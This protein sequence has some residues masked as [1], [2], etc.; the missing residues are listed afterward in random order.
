MNWMEWIGIAATCVVLLSFLQKSELNIRRVNIVGSILFVVYGLFI[1]SL[2]VWLLNGI[3]IIVHIYKLYRLFKSENTAS[4]KSK[5][6]ATRTSDNSNSSYY[7]GYKAGYE[8]GYDDG[9]NALTKTSQYTTYVSER[10][11]VEPRDASKSDDA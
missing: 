2:S 9:F 8:H 4:T 3:C 1:N 10:T 11:K 5:S 7:L 6:T